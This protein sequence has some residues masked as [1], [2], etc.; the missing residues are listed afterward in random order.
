MA[1]RHDGNDGTVYG[2]SPD[3]AA[4][5]PTS[6]LA[7]ILLGKI[8]AVW[9]LGNWFNER[10]QWDGLPLRG[11]TALA[12]AEAWAWLRQN[13]LVIAKPG[14]SSAH[15]VQLSRLGRDLNRRIQDGSSVLADV[16][17]RRL[18]SQ[19]T[20]AELERARGYFISGDFETAPFSA[21]RAVEIAVREQ[22]GL[23]DE[24]IGV[25]LVREALKGGG[26][27]DPGT[28]VVA[29]RDARAHLFA[30]AMGLFKNPSSHRPVDFD[31]PMAASEI[32]LLADL[33]LRLLGRLPSGRSAS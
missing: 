6:Q 28:D 21:M 18:V 24:L 13:G 15:G 33:L 32:V 3:E 31:D 29:E 25:A 11:E 2:I 20:A 23:P 30:G 17:S 1:S 26:P 5:L 22:A 9:H 14:E 12:W 16:E 4:V 8:E 27:L 19:V 7:M 10:N